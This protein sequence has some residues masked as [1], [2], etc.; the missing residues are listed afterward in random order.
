MIL[1][2]RIRGQM[3]GNKGLDRDIDSIKM[4]YKMISSDDNRDKTKC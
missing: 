3:E 1:E 4:H 2:T